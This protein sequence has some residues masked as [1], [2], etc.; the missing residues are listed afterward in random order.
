MLSGIEWVDLRK[1]FDTEP[2]ER[3]LVKLNGY[4]IKLKGKFKSLA[5]QFKC[6]PDQLKHFSPII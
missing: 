6:L 1:T 4:G 2:H 5:D 3:L